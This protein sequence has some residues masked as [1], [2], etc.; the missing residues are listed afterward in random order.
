[1]TDINKKMKVFK[2]VFLVLWVILTSVFILGALTPLEFTSPILMYGSFLVAF[3][4]LFAIR[5]FL[6]DFIRLKLA[7]VLI[8]LIISVSLVCTYAFLPQINNTWETDEILYRNKNYPDDI[9]AFQLDPR[10]QYGYER[11]TVK[12]EKFTPLFNYITELKYEEVMAAND[13]WIKVNKNVSE[14][15]SQK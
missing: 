3:N 6:T 12:I 2:T 10:G 13:P 5:F 9:I 14:V 4:G 8:S 7:K 11:R 1:M 15:D